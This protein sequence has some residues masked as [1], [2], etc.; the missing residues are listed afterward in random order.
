MLGESIGDLAGAR[1]AYRAF[2]K[3]LAA[4]PES[5]RDGFT[6]DQAFFISWGQWRG[7]TIRPESQRLMVQGDQHPI[8]KFR[9]NGPLSN[10]PEF[11]KAFGCP[12][13]APMVRSANLRCEVW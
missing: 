9:V 7:D 5:P 1:I 2:Q 11:Q 13:N 8:A 6:P 4:H 10:A 3:A 12:A